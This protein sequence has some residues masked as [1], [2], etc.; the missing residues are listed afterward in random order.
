MT[1]R[2]FEKKCN[3]RYKDAVGLPFTR[4]LEELD[5]PKP[6]R[7]ELF[8]DMLGDKKEHVIS[9]ED[10]NEFCGIVESSRTNTST[11]L[12]AELLK[13]GVSIKGERKSKSFTLKRIYKL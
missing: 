2:E 4:T 10:F 8:R 7:A 11:L 9:Y 6:T 1:V 3:S 5:K 13:L 12:R